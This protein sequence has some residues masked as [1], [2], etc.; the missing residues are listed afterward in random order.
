[1]ERERERAVE[2]NEWYRHTD[3]ERSEVA[4]VKKHGEKLKLLVAITTDGGREVDG[5]EKTTHKVSEK[6]GERE[7]RSRR[8]ERATKRRAAVVCP[9]QC[10][11]GN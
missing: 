2:Q 7:V 3:D 8:G 9:P 5:W 11:L 4:V 10:S 6:R 1:M